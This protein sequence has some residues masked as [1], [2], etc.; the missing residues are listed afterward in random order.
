MASFRRATELFLRRHEMSV[1]WDFDAELLRAFPIEYPPDLRIVSHECDECSQ[2]HD[3]FVQRT[4][5]SLTESAVNQH[6]TD[7]PLFTR[8]AFRYF[9]PAHLRAACANPNA[10]IAEFLLYQLGPSGIH[11]SE[12]SKYSSAQRAL[13]V[14]FLDNLQRVE[15]ID[16]KTWTKARARWAPA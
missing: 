3:D 11:T 1:A 12:L 9:L 14:K 10:K 15:V 7:L 2:L 5:A 16:H 6:Y 8:E 13:V 4:W